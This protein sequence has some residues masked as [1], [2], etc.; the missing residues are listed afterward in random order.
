MITIV[1]LP[2]FFFFYSRVDD[3]NSS[4]MTYTLF[5][6]TAAT[7][8]HI[9]CLLSWLTKAINLTPVGK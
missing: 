5:S 8:D 9:D 1:N 6:V 3:V 4:C 7:R 2:P